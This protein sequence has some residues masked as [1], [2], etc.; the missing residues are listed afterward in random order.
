FYLEN[1]EYL[2][3]KEL[4]PNFRSGKR[5]TTGEIRCVSAE[6]LANNIFNGEQQSLRQMI[7]RLRKK[8]SERLGADMGVPLDVDDFIENK[9]NQGSR[10]NRNARELASP[11]DLTPPEKIAVT[12]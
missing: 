7:T 1:T 6:T 8:I 11:A 4:L 9:P 12:G 10:I 2:F 5:T 3:I